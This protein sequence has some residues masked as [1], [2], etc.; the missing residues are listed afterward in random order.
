MPG[1][2][3]GRC[4]VAAIPFQRRA[5]PKRLFELRAIPLA[6]WPLPSTKPGS[7]PSRL[8]CRL[9]RMAPCRP[10]FRSGPDSLQFVFN[11]ER[12]DVGQAH[13]G[14]FPVG[15]T[16]YTFA[17]DERLAAIHYAVEDT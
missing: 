5:P 9:A 4:R 7:G 3:R 16:S 13:S 6:P 8:D 12:H 1:K 11:Q 14:F 2:N 17:F 15:K 10:P